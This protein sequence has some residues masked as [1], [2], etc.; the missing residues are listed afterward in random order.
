[1]HDIAI[2][3]TTRG[4]QVANRTIVADRFW[5]RLR[6]LLG[7]RLSEGEAMLLVPCRS[8]HTFGM[9][10]DLDVAFL[11]GD[12][13]VVSIYPQLRPNRASGYCAQAHAALELPARTLTS[14]GTKVGD[15][16]VFSSERQA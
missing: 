6:G 2:R 14:S 8:V 1:M 4:T 10:Y 13:R 5:S 9:G 15:Q 7:R 16:L 11:D 3:N 12:H